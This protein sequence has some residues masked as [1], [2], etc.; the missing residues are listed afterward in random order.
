MKRL[1]T[2][3]KKSFI[4]GFTA[5]FGSIFSS[6]I[7]QYIVKILFSLPE[8]N[9]GI[10]IE[11]P[12]EKLDVVG[13][14]KM[15]GFKMQTGATD[16]YVLTCDS[17]GNGTWQSST[18]G[19]G[20]SGTANYLTKFIAATTL[21]NTGIYETVA[22]NVGIGTKSPSCKLEVNG[23]AKVNGDI[24]FETKTGYVS[25]SA[26][27]FSPRTDGY[28]YTN[29]G[30]ELHPDNSISPTYYAPVQLPHNAKITKLTF[31]WEDQSIS[32]DCS[33][34][35]FRNTNPASYTMA[36]C[37]SSGYSGDGGSSDNTIPVS[38]AT[39]DNAHYS[40]YLK[41]YLPTSDCSGYSAILEYTYTEI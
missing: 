7:C 39:V 12:S 16:G 33:C 15:T 31:Y 4:F 10:G 26:A 24:F 3:N 22:G 2:R 21:G 32:D 8:G 5:G 11:N 27:A 20:G 9:V 35:L 6:K 30:M 41:W 25:V 14:V 36:E 23:N 38:Y 18:S 28:Q 17:S 1:L 37:S 40:Y 34:T 29:G 13:T 19:V